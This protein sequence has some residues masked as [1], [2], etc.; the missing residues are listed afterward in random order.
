MDVEPGRG[1]PPSGR[2]LVVGAGPVGLVG[3]LL[4]RHH[5]VEVD[6]VDRNPEAV[7]QSRA[8]DLHPATLERLD[9][10]GVTGELL[11]I[12]R[13]VRSVVVHT[14]GRVAGTIPLGR[15]GSPFPFALTVPQCTT[16]GV[17]QE[18]LGELGC[19]VERG[20]ELTTL[21]LADDVVHV[22]LRAVDGSTSEDRRRYDWV[23]GCDGSASTVRREL[24]I[25]AAGRTSRDVSA[26]ADVELDLPFPQD[27][28]HLVL[29][30]G[31]GVHVLP[32]PVAGYV[33][34]LLDRWHGE[35][36]ST[37]D[38]DELVALAGTRLGT[39]GLQARGARWTSSFLMHERVAT[40]LRDGRVLLAGDAAHVCP[41]VGGQGLNT[42]IGDVVSM[43][44][45]LVSVMRGH[46]PDS[47][48]DVV[49]A[50][51]RAIAARTGRAA[52]WA[53]AVN[54]PR[55][56]VSERVRD[57]AAPLGMRLAARP[58]NRWLAGS[59]DR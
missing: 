43:V 9:P 39:P 4:L 3:A 11:A 58:I 23:L 46:V 2:V 49:A 8:T 25:A 51:R 55:Y 14:A 17:L 10:Y 38:V 5:G 15:T 31:G 33:R 29:R 19:K 35:V 41:P 57:V 7:S 16:E 44:P 54:A 20:V 56:R 6:I 12:G 32:M 50:R 40:R 37:P 30:R 47:T 1:R 42:G 24:G 27:E 21:S 22:G 13:V 26:I 53:A 18:L 28:I 59:L 52:W 36:G 45:A 48:L 34:L